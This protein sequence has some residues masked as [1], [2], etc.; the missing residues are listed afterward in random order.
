MNFLE[1]NYSHKNFRNFK[2]TNG[3]WGG[4]EIAVIG[5][6]YGGHFIRFEKLILYITLNKEKSNGTNIDKETISVTKLGRSRKDFERF[7]KAIA[8]DKQKENNIQIY[9]MADYWYPMNQIPKRAMDTVFLEQDKKD[10]ILKTIDNLSVFENEAK[11][12]N[13]M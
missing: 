1:E 10:V 13:N 12:W 3:K 2:L 8:T 9:R 7:F 6:G 4:N 11:I 5:I